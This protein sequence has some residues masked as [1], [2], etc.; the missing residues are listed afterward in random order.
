MGV[1]GLLK[2]IRARPLPRARAT[3]RD[4]AVV[5]ALVL[6]AGQSSRM[7][8]RHK[9]LEP[10]ASGVPMVARVVD[11]LLA[12]RGRPIRVVVGHRADEVIAA[13]HGRPVTFVHA[14]D[15]AQG[16][17]ASL[18]AGLAAV[19][20][21]AVLVVLADMPLVTGASID[22]LIEAYDPDEGRLIVVPT[23]D[24]EWGNPVLWDRRYIPAMLALTGDSG[25][26]KL[27]R[28]HAD[29]MAEVPLDE[30]VLR[31]F[32]TPESLAALATES[33]A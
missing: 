17:S 24:G 10:D 6:A 30:S 23:H 15:Y 4:P 25:A 28:Q 20:E 22:R 29:A 16:L 11:H 19:T 14:A 1:G 3:Q 7:A 31:D 21:R 12:S 26:R 2:D 33:A 9:L 8:P 5:S 27:L 13:L 18:R 32:D